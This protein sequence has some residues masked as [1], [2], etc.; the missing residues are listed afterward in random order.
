MFFKFYEFFFDECVELDEKI[1]YK[2]VEDILEVGNLR[3][4][5]LM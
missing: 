2:L 5:E 1:V 3:F 4:D